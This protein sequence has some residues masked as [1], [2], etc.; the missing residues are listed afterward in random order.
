[1]RE[2][3]SWQRLE[4]LRACRQP[5]EPPVPATCVGSDALAPLAPERF[6]FVS[7]S[8]PEIHHLDIGPPYVARYEIPLAP[9]VGASHDF[10]LIDDRV[11]GACSWR[12]ARVEGLR[13]EDPLPSDHIRLHSDTGDP[14]L[15][16]FERE[17]G[18]ATCGGTI[19]RRYP[20]CVLESEPDDPLMAIADRG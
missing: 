16:V 12:I 15:I 7:R 2:S 10:R 13:T 9:A 5:T 8:F 18:T 17:F 20:P 6:R 4:G 19:D 14:G 1:L 11:Q 3:D